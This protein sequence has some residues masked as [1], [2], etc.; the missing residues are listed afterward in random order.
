M[1][2]ERDGEFVVQFKST[3][4]LMPNGII[5]ITGLPLDT[6]IYSSDVKIEDEKLA[7]LLASSLKPNKKKARKSKLTTTASNGNVSAVKSDAVVVNTAD[8]VQ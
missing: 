1:F 4:L 5:K 8:S 2:Y 6:D 7:A 3:V